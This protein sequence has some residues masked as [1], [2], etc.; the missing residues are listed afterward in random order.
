MDAVGGFGLKRPNVSHVKNVCGQVKIRD[1]DSDPN[2]VPS[3]LSN[4]KQ[5]LVFSSI[6][7]MFS[8]FVQSLAQT[9]YMFRRLGPRITQQVVKQFVPS[10]VRSV[11]LG[12]ERE[13]QHDFCYVRAQGTRLLASSSLIF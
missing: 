12:G 3:K 2:L 5:L 6:M 8:F 13:K 1:S 4:L 7:A 9:C 11:R 10:G